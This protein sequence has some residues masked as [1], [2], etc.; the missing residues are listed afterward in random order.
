MKKIVIG[1]VYSNRKFGGDE[2][3]FIRVA[4]KK[5]V[6]LIFFNLQNKF[7]EGEIEEK[8]KECD[9]FFNNTSEPFT[10]E[11]IKTLEEFGKKVVDSSKIGYYIEDKWIFYLKCKQNK[12]PTPETILLSENLNSA[13][14]EL[15]SF[16][17]WPVILKRVE[18]DCGNYVDKADN[19]TD[20]EKI[21][22][23][24]WKKGS[25]KKSIIAQEFIP[26]FSY[27]VTTI[28]D[29]IV[30]TAIK[31]SHGWKCTGVYEKKCDKFKIDLK[32]KRIVKKLLKIVK[33]EVCGIDFLKKDGKWVVLEVNATPGLDFFEE[34]R[35][36]LV[37]KIIDL[38][39]KKLKDKVNKQNIS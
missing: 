26:S 11:F 31:K 22:K 38:L 13:K 16:N 9:I 32:L 19:F 37:G 4:K 5:G 24:F 17:H 36:N 20:A 30:Q 18:G 7:N 33:I 39:L 14:E 15:K 28:G 2:K 3:S 35:D 29:K 21:I 27:R 34:E 6:K 12:I 8:S 23:H 25:E 1:Y 10:L